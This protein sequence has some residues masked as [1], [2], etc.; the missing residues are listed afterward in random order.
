MCHCNEI[1]AWA[2]N[3]IKETESQMIYGA[4]ELELEFEA[5]A[6]SGAAQSFRETI[7]FIESNCEN[8]K[9]LRNVKKKKNKKA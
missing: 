8:I 3:S 2:K 5:G 7:S 4:S 1:L 9:D 6:R